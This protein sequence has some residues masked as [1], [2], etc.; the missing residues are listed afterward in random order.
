M[1]PS[2]NTTT[3][4]PRRH[5][6]YPPRYR[7]WK[8]SSAADAPEI[9]VRCEVDGAI[10]GPEGAAPQ[11]VLIK[12]LNEYDIKGQVGTV[13]VGWEPGRERRAGPEV[14]GAA[15]GGCRF[16]GAVALACGFRYT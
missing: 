7:K 5:G 9:V 3:L 12:A 14:A 11:T 6:P 2:I 8:L 15:Q 13:L 4:S 16:R 1:P 10:K